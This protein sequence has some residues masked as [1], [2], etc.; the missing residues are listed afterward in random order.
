MTDGFWDGAEIISSYSRAQAIADGSLVDVTETAKEAGFKLPTVLTRGAW[1]DAVDWSDPE[2]PATQDEAGRLWD[3][4]FL[5]RVAAGRS[6]DTDLVKFTVARVPRDRP[7]GPP[8][9]LLLWA[10][11]GPGDAGEPVLTVMRPEDY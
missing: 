7:D 9:D 8:E 11:V 1:V 3:V 4:L 6:R 2:L 5:A 10:H